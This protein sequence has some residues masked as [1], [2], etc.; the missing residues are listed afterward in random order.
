LAQQAPNMHNLYE[1]YYRVYAALNVRDIDGILR[2]Q[3][4]QMP[5]DPAQE[6]ADVMDSMELKVFAGQQHDAHILSHLMMGL[7]PMLQALPQAAIELQK[8][9]LEHV[10]VKA[11]EDTAAELF[12][13]YGT[14]PDRM[15]SDL[16]R[17]A[18]VAIKATQYMQ[19]VRDMQNGLTGQ[20]NQPDPVV[21]LKEKEIA[22]RTQAEQ[23]RAAEAKAK[24]SLDTQKAQ[25]NMQMAQARLASQERI[26]GQ[27]ASTARERIVAADFMQRRRDNAPQKRQ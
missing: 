22:I 23:N 14:D 27:R 1:A 11:E 12:L 21:L 3:N 19:Q 10:R 9:I 2:P 26:A 15:V 24:L 17:E 5:K 6:N 20:N 8:H 13:Q 16:Q 18:L 25:Q 7:S 4:T